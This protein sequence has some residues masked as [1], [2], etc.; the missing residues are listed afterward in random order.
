MMFARQYNSIQHKTYLK[1]FTTE[2]LHGVEYLSPNVRLTDTA[3]IQ[4]NRHIS[5]KFVYN[6]QLSAGNHNTKVSNAV[7]VDV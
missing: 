5:N 7:H 6:T 3:D 2:K 4:Q 1:A